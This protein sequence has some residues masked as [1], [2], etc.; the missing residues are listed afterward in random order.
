MSLFS[1][2]VV[3]V[4]ITFVHYKKHIRYILRECYITPHSCKNLIQPCSSGDSRS[5]CNILAEFSWHGG[6]MHKSSNFFPLS[7][8][9]V[10]IH[11]CT[12]SPMI[13]YCTHKVYLQDFQ[14][15]WECPLET[16]YSSLTLQIYQ[17]I[18]DSPKMFFRIFS[19]LFRKNLKYIRYQKMHVFLMTLNIHFSITLGKWCKLFF[20]RHH[21]QYQGK[22]YYQNNEA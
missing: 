7:Y 20:L 3:F 11:F 2:I 5:I 12:Y 17:D 9:D 14:F 18:P 21:A 10:N 13:T 16:F 4:I 8:F 1:F 19:C 6:R 15:L 22:Y